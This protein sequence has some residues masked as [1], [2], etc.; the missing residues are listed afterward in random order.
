MKNSEEI[1]KNYLSIGLKPNLD[2]KWDR[3][4]KEYIQIE[5]KQKKIIDFTSGIL[6][7]CLGYKNKSLTNGLKKVI[8][9]GFVHAYHY[10]TDI[11]N[12]YIKSLNDFT[13]DL[14]DHPKFYL[15]SSGTEATETCMKL[16]LRSGQKF[17][18]SKNKILTIE[19]NYHG[20]TM[21]SALMSS[22]SIYKEVWPLLNNLFPKI[23]F[24]YIWNVS[25][26]NGEDF[27]QEEIQKLDEETKKNICGVLIE[28]YQGWGACS[29]PKSFIKAIE[30]YC[31]KNNIVFA[32][33][34]MQSGFY[35]TSS[36]FGY[37]KYDVN[38]DIICIGKGMGGGLPLSG[39]IG[40]SK[41]MDLALPGE[42]SSTH[43]CNPLS[44][45]AGHT[46]LN[47]MKNPRFINQLNENAYLFSSLGRELCTKYSFLTKKS[48][49]LGMVGA[50]IFDLD[51]L[52]KS[53]LFANHFCE[54]A[55]KKGILVIKTGRE[56]VKLSPPL[57]IKKNN[58]Y[59]AFEIFDMILKSF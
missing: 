42:L 43:S 45:A 27:F 14:F 52:E 17:S 12:I 29:Y 49:F 53:I 2:I 48:N 40:E 10:A 8:N 3:G 16:M 55:L 38:P 44:C 58:I 46:V 25:E 34:E 50:F 26:E 6:V 7:N 15:T 11:K 1:L 51:D 19:G 24:P 18:P 28:T 36:K 13:V 5:G 31:S 54:A 35:R 59:K 9:N 57:I 21:G 23:N 39:L 22:G 30:K 37:E 32:F 41:I 20:R 47:I 33:D 4:W 56:S